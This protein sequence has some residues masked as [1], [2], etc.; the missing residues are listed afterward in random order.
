MNTPLLINANSLRIPLTDQS[1]QM[2]A[3]SPPYYGLRDYQQAGQIGLENSVNEYVDN[4]VAVFREVWRVL[5]NDG[6]L[7]LNLG[8]SYNGSGGAGGDYNVG[9]LKE[10]QPRYPGRRVNGLKPKDLIGVPWRVAFALQSEGWY[11]RSDIIWSKPNPM[12]ES[13]TDRPTKSHEYIFLLTKSQKYFYDAEAIKE[14]SKDPTDNRAA[15]EKKYESREKFISRLKPEYRA[16][17]PFRNRRSVWT[18][19]TQPYSSGRDVDH[20]ACWPPALVEPMIKAGTSEKGCCPHCGRAW[21]RVTETEREPRPW[22]TKQFSDRNDA[23][24]PQSVRVKVA[25]LDWQPACT[26]PPRDPIPCTILDPFAGSGTTLMVA[27]QLGRRAVGLD[28]SYTYLKECARPRLGMDALEDWTN[29]KAVGTNG[30][31]ELPLFAE[32]QP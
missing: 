23:G 32:L 2:V 25:T 14:P 1:V 11:L 13:V 12:P 26:C 31:H 24:N 19:A 21:V 20:F 15:R 29:G 3:T 30:Y 28:L 4:L 9:G 7:F 16:D 17:L 8:D 22:V 27:R 10:G 18:V 6:V 5:R